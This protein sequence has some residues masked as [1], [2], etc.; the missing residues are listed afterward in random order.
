MYMNPLKTGKLVLF[1]VRYLHG[2]ETFELLPF[3]LISILGG[4]VG[5]F[6]IKMNLKMCR[7]RKTTWLRKWPVA[8][9][10]AVAAA[11][12]IVH[13]LNPYLRGGA[14]KIIANLVNECNPME[15]HS[16]L[17][18]L[19]PTQAGETVGLLL[20]AALARTFLT[21]FTFG[22]RVPA[23]LFIP[24][25]AIGAALGRAVGIGMQQLVRYYPEATVFSECSQATECVTPGV[26]AMLGA[27]AV[28][29]GV[30]RMTVSLVVIIFELT[31][32]LSVMVPIMFAVL[33][34]KWVG[35]ALGVDGIYDEHILLN[36]YPFLDNKAEYRFNVPASEVMT[37]GKMTVI[38]V[39]SWTHEE[40]RPAPTGAEDDRT[41]LGRLEV[42]TG[43]H[44]V[45]SLERL[46]ESHPYT[47]F[48]LVREGDVLVG[49]IATREL[50]LALSR[51]RQGSTGAQGEPTT[52]RRLQSE[53]SVKGSTLCSFTGA[54]IRAAQRT[55][56]QSEAQMGEDIR[57]SVLVDLRQFVQKAPL[58]VSSETSMNV[59]FSL[60]KKLG[61]RHLLI[62]NRGRV[63]GLLTKKDVLQHIAITIHHTPRKFIRRA[64]GVMKTTFRVAPGATQQP[65]MVDLSP[66]GSLDDLAHL[67]EDDDDDD[68]DSNRNSGSAGGTPSGRRRRAQLSADQ[69]SL[70]EL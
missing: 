67:G 49:F 69:P 2:F 66:V 39:H 56:R 45:D 62:A 64:G 27:A 32:E 59:V 17:C 5:A 14:S 25:L 63:I 29:G 20:L 31:G 9:A 19:D 26:Y 61:V 52:L 36:E 41:R 60:F 21:I 53:P 57:R 10:C 38:D 33:I 55:K 24:S 42:I 22:L 51:A 6:F 18:S 68:G 28:L 15:T 46:I 48:P 13:F 3:L 8:E 43:P 50:K 37:S 58:S 7:V 11:T 44:T 65:G 40:D 34:A 70:I 35:D 4:V 1:E 54:E 23:G 47:G 16:P 12:A 30:T